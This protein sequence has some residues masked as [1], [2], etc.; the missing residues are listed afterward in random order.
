MWLKWWRN[1]SE[2]LIL[3]NLYQVLLSFTYRPLQ[4]LQ[5]LCNTLFVFVSPWSN[6][7]YGKAYLNA[8]LEEQRWLT[9]IRER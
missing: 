8:E 1:E 7:V 4:C 3:F 6:N 9:Y 5:K 2:E